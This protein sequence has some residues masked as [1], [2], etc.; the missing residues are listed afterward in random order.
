[1]IQNY[2]FIGFKVSPEI[3]YFKI[4]TKVTD[5]IINIL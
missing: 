5:V 3:R 1:M 2:I 4:V